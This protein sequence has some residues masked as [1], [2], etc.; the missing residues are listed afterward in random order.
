L[1]RILSIA[2]NT[3]RESVR[4]RILYNLVLFVLLIT[5]CAVLLGDLTDGQEARTIVNFGLNAML[6]FGVFIAIFV[7]VGLVSKEIEKKTVYAIFAKPVR[8]GEFIAGKYLGLCATLFVNVLI[9]GVGVS[10]ALLYVKGSSLIGP[11][12][13]AIL[14]IFFEL[15]IVTSVAILFSSFSTPSLSA[16]LTFLVFIIGHLS[17]SLRELAVTLQSKA[18]AY[19]LEAIYYLLPNLSLFSFRT[20]AAL[21][22]SPGSTAIIGALAYALC[23]I[24]IVLTISIVIFTRR[25]FK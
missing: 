16:L 4:D 21:G 24:V 3:F 22:I 11:A 20:E 18:T 17:A 10:L 1:K 13:L 7:G 23:Y 6:L 8:R 5:A 12:W 2:K 19:V 15:M 14:L 25:D 9:M